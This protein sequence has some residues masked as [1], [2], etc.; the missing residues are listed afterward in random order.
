MILIRLPLLVLLVFFVG[1][2]V[3]DEIS[4]SELDLTS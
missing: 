2:D 3:D 1:F 4:V